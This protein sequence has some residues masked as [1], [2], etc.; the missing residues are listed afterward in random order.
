M[1]KEKFTIDDLA[2]NI[3]KLVKITSQGFIDQDKKVDQKIDKLA[4]ITAQGFIDQDKKT[5]QKIEKLTTIMTQGFINQD[6]KT[7]DKIDNLARLVVN[8]HE[9]LKHEF[10]SKFSQMDNRMNRLEI[11]QDDIKLRLDNVAY[12]FELNEL[13]KRVSVLEKKVSFSK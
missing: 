8:G 1:S 7:E 11:G 13:N 9:E 3:D 12:R 6:K 5:D 10:N 2:N 4:K